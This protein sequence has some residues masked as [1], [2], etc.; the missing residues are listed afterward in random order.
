MILD[1]Q[2]RSEAPTPH[3]GGYREFA[4]QFPWKVRSLGERVPN[5]IGHF[6]PPAILKGHIERERH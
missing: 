1:L 3:G 2:E 4:I 5:R 6:A